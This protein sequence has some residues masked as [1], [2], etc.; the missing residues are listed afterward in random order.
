MPPLVLEPFSRPQVWGGRRLPRDFGKQADAGV[1]IGESWEISGH[2]LHES[3]VQEGPLAGVPLNDLWRQHRHEWCPDPDLVKLERFPW[4]IKLL[5][6]HE[7]SSVQIHPNDA[8]VARLQPGESGKTEAW[9]VLDTVPGSRLYTGLLP[10]LTETM[11]RQRIA[12]GTFTEFL[13]VV[14]P[15]PGEAYLIPAG[16]VHAI[17]AGLVLF[18]IE[19]CSDITLRLFDWDRVDELGNSRT[20]HVDEALSCLDE[21]APAATAARPRLLPESLPGVCVERLVSCRWF[22]VDRLILDAIAWTVL[23]DRLTVWFVA[24]GGCRLETADGTWARDCGVGQTILAP[25]D[26]QPLRWCRTSPAECTLLRCTWPDHGA[27]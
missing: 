20:L 10:G 4:L 13:Q 6:C 3:R 1:K 5:D 7:P 17:G 15:Q 25:G 21:T 22:V 11:L 27:E 24:G 9:Y 14:T 8:Q 26:P 18:E 19:Q 12:D 23:A 16:T 2:P